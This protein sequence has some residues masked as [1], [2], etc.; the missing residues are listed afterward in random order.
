MLIGPF[1]LSLNRIDQPILC[2]RR[3]F[4]E[5][6]SDG[7]GCSIVSPVAVVRPPYRTGLVK[8]VEL[9]FTNCPLGVEADFFT[10]VELF[11]EE[12]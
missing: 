11:T 12:S 10:F 7:S 6:T 1:H 9:P 8:T 2:R 4:D 3:L 5:G